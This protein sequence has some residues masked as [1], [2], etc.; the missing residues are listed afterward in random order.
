MITYP[1]STMLAISAASPPAYVALPSLVS[2]ND[3]QDEWIVLTV[4][5]VGVGEKVGADGKRDHGEC[6]G[7][8]L[9]DDAAGE[10]RN[11]VTV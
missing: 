1:M 6:K 2:R 8:Q 10:V 3:G 5:D 11:S 4:E 7:H 9:E